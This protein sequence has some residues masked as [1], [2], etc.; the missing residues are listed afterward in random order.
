[1]LDRQDGGGQG[2]FRYLNEYAYPLNTMDKPV[3]MDRLLTFMNGRNI[4]GLGRWGE[5]SHFNSDV[6][7]K[8]ALELSKTLTD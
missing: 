2:R 6:V 4:I 8:K 3:I 7:I 5:H 1:M